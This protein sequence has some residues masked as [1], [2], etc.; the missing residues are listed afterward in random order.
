ML[1]RGF[2]QYGVQM[3]SQKKLLPG[4]LLY[5]SLKINAD[6]FGS[7]AV[8]LDFLDRVC[9]NL[10]T[11]WAALAP[12]NLKDILYTFFSLC[13]CLKCTPL[14]NKLK[15]MYFFLSLDPLGKGAGQG[16]GTR[17]FI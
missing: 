8:L 1:A 12:Y 3:Q 15:K 11:G 7:Y 2:K 4:Y 9:E 10:T 17:R 14:L 16:G 5:A 13:W 6:N